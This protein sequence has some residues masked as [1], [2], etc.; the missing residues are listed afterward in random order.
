VPPDNIL[1][2]IWDTELVISYFRYNNMLSF[3]LPVTGHRSTKGQ[4][5]ARGTYAV[6]PNRWIAVGQNSVDHEMVVWV[7]SVLSI[8]NGDRL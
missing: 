8:S 4:G 1:R 6:S 7:E 2:M 5:E 3:I